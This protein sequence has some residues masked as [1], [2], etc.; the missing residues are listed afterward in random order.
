MYKVSFSDF[1]ALM[2]K[3]RKQERLINNKNISISSHFMHITLL[4]ALQ[5]PQ[6]INQYYL[7]HAIKEESE[8]S[9][10]RC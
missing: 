3:A 7:H 8:I 4:Y 2:W 9:G 1:T 10:V 5:K 6:K